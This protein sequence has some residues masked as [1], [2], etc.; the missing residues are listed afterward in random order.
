ML[1]YVVLRYMDIMEIFKPTMYVTL[2]ISDTNLDSS[3]SAIEKSVNISNRHFKSCLERHHQ[4]EV[5][6]YLYK[7]MLLRKLNYLVF[8]VQFKNIN[9]IN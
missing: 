7:L 9:N 4:S 1:K 8:H 2:S 5:S 3:L 6:I